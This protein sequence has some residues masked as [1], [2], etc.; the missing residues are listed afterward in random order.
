MN[1]DEQKQWVVNRLETYLTMSHD[2]IEADKEDFEGLSEQYISV[3]EKTRNTFL[4]AVGFIATVV[5]LG[6]ASLGAIEMPYV[7]LFLAIDLS[8]GLVVFIIYNYMTASIGNE[9]TTVWTAHYETLRKIEYIQ[10]HIAGHTL[11]LD[12][13]SPNRINLL[14]AWSVTAVSAADYGLMEAYKK[15]SKAKFLSFLSGHFDYKMR[16]KESEFNVAYKNYKT[17]FDKIPPDE[18][19]FE[20]LKAILK[21]MEEMYKKERD[22][23]K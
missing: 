3:L 18:V 21:P 9:L 2:E 13:I 8:V 12:S 17:F 11:F 15:A 16:E 5:I 6:L 7:I 14:H 10:G 22:Q 20:N 1:E 19:L 23:E 4:A